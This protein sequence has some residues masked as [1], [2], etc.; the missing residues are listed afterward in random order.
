MVIAAD[1]AEEAC[2]FYREEIGATLP[3]VIE[4]LPYLMEVCC[5]DGSLKQVKARIN[6]EMDAR[7]SWLIMGIPCE[8]HQPFIIGTLP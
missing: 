2:E 3:D 5:D 8:L 7:N 6:E 4:E 1:T